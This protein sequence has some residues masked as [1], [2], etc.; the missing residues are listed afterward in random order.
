MR[1]I[2]AACFGLVALCGSAAFAG[3]IQVIDSNVEKYP[4]GK[5]LPDTEKFEDLPS[6]GRVRVLVLSSQV[7]RIY[8]GKRSRRPGVVG[9]ARGIRPQ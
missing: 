3:D 5:V 1:F 2:C 6:D 8:E 9:G 7:T 4:V